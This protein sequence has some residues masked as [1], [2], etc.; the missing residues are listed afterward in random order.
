MDNRAFSAVHLRVFSIP[1]YSDI[2]TSL[3]RSRCGYPV[4]MLLGIGPYLLAIPRAPISLELWHTWPIPRMAV[5]FSSV[6]VQTRYPFGAAIY[7][8]MGK[9]EIM[10]WMSSL[11]AV[12]IPRRTAISFQRARAKANR[13]YSREA[14]IAR[15]RGYRRHYLQLGACSPKSGI[16]YL[17]RSCPVA[18]LS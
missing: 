10:D 8:T 18:T 2:A 3:T 4:N 7:V 12:R 5:R 15:P 6:R 13:A 11:T 14:C 16:N 9:P 17:S 1:A